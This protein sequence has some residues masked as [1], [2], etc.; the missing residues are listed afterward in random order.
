ME[1]P[2][3]AGTPGLI[4]HNSISVRRYTPVTVTRTTKTSVFVKAGHQD[5]AERRFVDAADRR[6]GPRPADYREYGEKAYRAAELIVDPSLIAECLADGAAE[7]ARRDLEASAYHAISKLRSL[8][9]G[10]PVHQ[11][12]E[13]EILALVSF[14]AFVTPPP[15]AD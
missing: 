14:A 2:I 8:F 13:A 9:E 15:K 6:Y 4:K 3:A 7:K 12:T 11:R 1:Q 5:A 10:H